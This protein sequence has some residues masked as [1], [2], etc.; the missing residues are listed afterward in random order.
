MLQLLYPSPPLL[1]L[2]LL[3]PLL[4]L[5]LPPQSLPLPMPRAHMAASH[6]V[7]HPALTK[8][9]DAAPHRAPCGRCSVCALLDDTAQHN[10]CVQGAQRLF[11]V[12]KEAGWHH[13][14]QSERAMSAR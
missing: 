13:H 8:R 2:L 9:A 6:C 10:L 4:P 11:E 7:V 1:L 5:P 3:P 12:Q 14:Q